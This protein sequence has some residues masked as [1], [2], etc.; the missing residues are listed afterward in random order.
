MTEFIM[1]KRTSF[2][3]FAVLS[4]GMLT[5]TGGA[6]VAQNITPKIEVD[7]SIADG[8]I[9]GKIVDSSNWP[10]VRVTV[11]N[12]HNY[13]TKIETTTNI[14][15]TVEPVNIW[16]KF[17]F[18]PGDGDAIYQLTY[19]SRH[20]AFVSFFANAA[21]TQNGGTPAYVIS[22]IEG[23]IKVFTL[24]TFNN[25][26]LNALQDVLSQLDRIPDC[27]K[28]SDN[29]YLGQW[30]NFLS[31]INNCVVKDEKQQQVVIYLVQKL[32]VT[33]SK[34]SIKNIFTL[35]AI[36]GAFED[37]WDTLS[38][39]VQG[40]YAGT[41]T[42]KSEVDPNVS[43]PIITNPYLPIP[44]D[45]N[46][47]PAPS[48][49]SAIFT[50]QNI[51]N[52]TVFM[53]GQSFV[54]TWHIANTGRTTWRGYI[55]SFISGAS[56]NA[57]LDVNVPE[58]PPGGTADVS[59]P[60]IAPLSPG[61]PTGIWQLQ[62]NQG[63]AISGYARMI[64]RV[65]DNGSG[66]PDIPVPNPYQPVNPYVPN[67][68]AVEI[69]C[70]DCLDLV[71]P[72]SIYRP[73]VRVKINSDAANLSEARGDML[74]N[75]DGQL[76]EAYSFMGVTGNVNAGQSYDFT[77][78]ENDPIRVPTTEGT[79]STKWRLWRNGNWLGPELTITFQASNSASGNRPPNAPK[80]KSP[81]DWYVMDSNQ[82]P[83]LVAEA[84]GDPDGDAITQYYFKFESSV[85]SCNS[86]W[87][88][89][90]SWQPDCIVSEGYIWQ[91]KVRDARGQE[92]GWSEPWHIS[93]KDIT[94]RVTAFT[95]NWRTPKGD[96]D[97]CGTYTGE[98]VRFDLYSFTDN[99]WFN[100]DAG[101]NTAGYICGNWPQGAYP[102]GKYK[103]RLFVY[104]KGGG[105]Y[106]DD[107]KDIIVDTPVDQPP[108][109]P[110]LVNP[111]NTTGVYVNSQ[112]I[113]F[114]WLDGY[115]ANNY[116]LEVATDANFSNHVLDT[117]TTDSAYQATIPTDYAQLY[118]RVTSN[119]TYGSRDNTATFGIDVT[120]PDSTMIAL[121]AVTGDTLFTVKWN[122][123]DARAGVRW[124]HV[125]VRD[126]NRPD[127][128]WL[129]WK[130]NTTETSASFQARPGHTYYFRVRAMDKI[131]NWE[132]WPSNPDGDTFTLVNPTAAQD[133]TWWNQAYGAKRSLLLLNKDSDPLPTHYPMHV[134][135]DATTQPTAAEIYQGALAN[136]ND[137]RVLY[138]NQTELP[139][140]V[141]RFSA[142]QIDLWF[143]L[144]ADIGGSADDTTHYQ[145]YYGNPAA[146]AR[147]AVD[148][149]QIFLPIAD[150]NT[151]LLAHFQEGQGSTV[152]DS[153]GRGHN[154]TFLN[155]GWTD[156][157]MG[158][159]GTFNGK[160][161]GIKFDDKGDFNAGGP[162]TLESWVY[163]TDLNVDAGMIFYKGIGGSQQYY[164]RVEK[165]GVNFGKVCEG[166]DEMFR[167]Y[168]FDLN[169]WYHVAGVFDGQKKQIYVNGVK[170]GKS[171]PE[172]PTSNC[173][174]RSV[175]SPVFMGYGSD[176]QGV[177]FGGSIQ[178]ARISNVARTDF[179]YALITT[180]PEV[181][182]GALRNK[183]GTGTVD[184]AVLNLKTYPNSGGGLI[185]QALVQNQGNATTGNE[186]FTDIYLN[187]TPTGAG[188][189]TGSVHFW[190]TTPIAAGAT[191]TLTT[192][193]TPGVITARANA[194]AKIAEQVVD[195]AMQA[196][197]VGVISETDKTN[198][199][200]NL[201]ACLSAANDSY[202]G[203]NAINSAREIKLD[204]VQ[205]HNFTQIS[206]Q[207]WLKFTA[208]ADE[209]YLIQTVNLDLAAD[210]TLTLYDIDQTTVITS[211]DDF[212]G[213]LASAISWVAPKSGVYYLKVTNWNPNVKDCGTS[214]DV[215]LIV[216]SMN[217]AKAKT[218]L[219]VNVTA[220]SEQGS[221]SYD[222]TVTNLNCPTGWVCTVYL[223]ADVLATSTPLPATATN[224]PLPTSTNTPLPTSTDTP[225]PTNT[226]I[227]T[228]TPLPTWTPIRPNNNLSVYL[229]LL[230]KGN[231]LFN[232]ATWSKIYVVMGGTNLS[233]SS[234][235]VVYRWKQSYSANDP[236]RDIPPCRLLEQER[237]TNTPVEVLPWNF[238]CDTLPTVTPTPT[239][240]A[241]PTATDIPT[242]T[243]TPIPTDTPM[244]TTTST[245]TD[246]P[247]PTMTA[248][249]MNTPA[250]TLTPTAIPTSNPNAVWTITGNMQTPRWGH[251]LTLLPNGKVLA[252]GGLV[253]SAGS[254]LLA[255]AEIYDPATGQWTA[256]GNM[257]VAR[258][259]HRATLLPNGKVLVVG[260]GGI[261]TAELYDPATGQWSL[262]GSLNTA[263]FGHLQV[264]LPNGKV[265]VAGGYEGS[266]LTSAELYDPATGKWS[267]TGSL[268]I[269][270]CWL[271][272]ALLPDGKVLA[273]SGINAT[274]T[275]GFELYDP[276]TGQWTVTTGSNLTYYG[277][278]LALLTDGK[279]LTAGGLDTTSYATQKISSVH[280]PNSTL[281][282]AVG[283]LNVARY[284]G[285]MLLL[286]NGEVIMVGGI[287]SGAG[288]GNEIASTEIYNPTSQTWRQVANLNVA[289]HY[290]EA[291]VLSDGR[292]LIA[293]GV[294]NSN[295][296][297]SST[298]LYGLASQMPTPTPTPAPQGFTLPKNT[299]GAAANHESQ[300]TSYRLNGTLGQPSLTLPMTATN[301]QLQWGYWAQ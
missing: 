64:I 3:L 278:A 159:A 182:A 106:F 58:T 80:L 238:S 239:I 197:S 12:E 53:P 160:T 162:L 42:F 73:T 127:S 91:V 258:N 17:G 26:P 185:V 177:A 135:F 150:G 277:Y 125:Q 54:Q 82:R 107:S 124:Y 214:Y 181:K 205:T 129:D 161:S 66:N 39:M 120:P 70:L 31:N 22:V 192:V 246:T 199:I 285:S 241:I 260:G 142:T 121:P 101:S 167:G 174:P 11:H 250:P 60:M 220:L 61:E 114:D 236:V 52:G 203:D 46:P 290:A 62:N 208:Q 25:V 67:L 139:L 87:I 248:T 190:S 165:G 249:V 113:Q 215:S 97:F 293:G 147:S 189:Y 77:F 49:D 41:I 45:P 132:A 59:V 50:G 83:T 111:S 191:I 178:H 170:F 154:G 227:P 100:I 44:P 30:L 126:G 122:A 180:E 301:Y 40:S 81:G 217:L 130:V 133:T 176:Y 8:A 123:T 33:I 269:A 201:S 99:Q 196:D 300:S 288:N 171:E 151:L 21:R 267:P 43:W 140:Y 56:M 28:A 262:T 212:S 228:W 187:H 112:T 84:N 240:T 284:G 98:G 292:V 279:L 268:N 272:G 172:F 163:I 225:V 75:T 104:I 264:L 283:N 188:D 274:N 109:T 76:F 118:W 276:V 148:L 94:P 247:A 296:I 93:V 69:T 89:N 13:W 281:W 48:S 119:G 194:R 273:L 146:P 230:I 209:S 291:I 213:T 32:G 223:P 245:P 153:S 92:S 265:L 152:A 204:E 226:P 255:S 79:Y 71:P 175:T 14:G 103:A 128:Q 216:D 4:L 183:P 141:Q 34:E 5:L 131:N 63:T 47:Q 7:Q 85:K 6:A 35:W 186:V 144:Q 231:N 134:H 280:D 195:V 222:G 102:S 74:R 257:N 295:S 270:R 237:Q 27:V 16:A 115:R 166:M 193:L 254:S 243:N 29:L 211:N 72:G 51:A 275:T 202:E 116:R 164:L 219:G 110:V 235:H 251:S 218:A 15:V 184:L 23:V 253:T 232:L 36:K 242:P 198:N 65:Q 224:T 136:G 156:G 88:S 78:Y 55:L 137:V 252:T 297:L 244:P 105:L 179:P 271:L 2:W 233:F 282:T 10:I 20:N 155:G 38:S 158:Y 1:L 57:P 289:R 149:N 37:I 234:G 68:P 287:D 138:N 259:S 24:R 200:T 173:T 298:E 169:R 299:F 143:P 108:N 261:A 221:F 86:G 18:I 294:G 256:T 9:T 207:D 263:R 96:I 210:T 19:D 229:P 206:D 168:T 95:M 157:W 145:L 90:A 286:Y 266:Y 117:T